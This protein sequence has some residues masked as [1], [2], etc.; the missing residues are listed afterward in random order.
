D[1]FGCVQLQA[2]GTEVLGAARTDR[3]TVDAVLF[4]LQEQLLGSR[5]VNQL[6]VAGQQGELRLLQTAAAGHPIQS[7]ALELQIK[8]LVAGAVIEVDRTLT[9][10]LTGQGC[11]HV[12]ERGT[13]SRSTR[14]VTA[15][16]EDHHACQG[17]GYRTVV[18]A[19][20]EAFTA[21]SRGCLPGTPQSDGP[22]DRL[23]YE[24]FPLRSGLYHT[25]G[26][27]WVMQWIL[28]PPS[29][30]SRPGTI[31]TRLSGN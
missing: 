6:I 10:Q 8:A 24:V 7:A 12:L 26:C 27:C 1:R 2:E 21:V 22:A 9:G 16:Q 5:A 23:Y 31:T 19:H 3:Q 29:N 15:R 28:P 18:D 11:W 20:E 14:F 25:A 17:Q 13:G 30:I 4:R